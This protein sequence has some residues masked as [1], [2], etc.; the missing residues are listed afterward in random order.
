MFRKHQGSE[1]NQHIRVIQRRV[2]GRQHFT[3]NPIHLSSRIFPLVGPHLTEWSGPFASCNPCFWL[4]LTLDWTVARVDNP[5]SMKLICHPPFFSLCLSFLFPQNY[6]LCTHFS[7]IAFSVSIQNSPERVRK[8]FP[9]GSFYLRSERTYKRCT[10]FSFLASPW[11][12]NFKT[13]PLDGDKPFSVLGVGLIVKVKG[14]F[15]V[16][17]EKPQSCLYRWYNCRLQTPL[18][19]LSPGIDAD[20]PPFYR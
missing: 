15:R 14:S 11:G 1:L 5:T 20:F 18:H 9:G 17:D 19:S 13:S 2:P 12:N 6:L 10:F 16:W 7:S 3:H 4:V 8:V